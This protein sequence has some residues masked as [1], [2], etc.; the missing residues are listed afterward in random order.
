VL[1]SNRI[2]WRGFS[3]FSAG[4]SYPSKENFSDLLR[5]YTK[6][7]LAPALLVLLLSQ[8]NT[9]ALNLKTSGKAQQ[10]TEKKPDTPQGAETPK[11][12]T[13]PKSG[14]EF[15][16][17]QITE[18]VILTY[19]TRPGLE[20]IRR[21]GIERG[22]MTRI[23]TDGRT[24]EASYERRFIRGASADK[25]K[26]R[27]DQK[28]PTIEY[29]LVYGEGHMWGLINGSAFTPREDATL[30][31]QA[32]LWHGLDALLRYK[33]N[34]S[35]V[36]LGGK[37]KQLGVEYY[38]IDLTDKEKRHTR[39]YI[40]TKTLRV[41]WLEY[42]E[43]ARG[44]GLASAKF[45]RR[46]YDYRLA[47]GTLVPYRTVFFEDGKQTQETRIMTVTFGI[48]MEDSLFQNPDAPRTN[49]ASASQ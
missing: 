41:M 33:E 10:Q 16:A 38:V 23:G 13:A 6:I 27:L 12:A 21:N 5:R 37:E 2:K 42:E 7:A 36:A 9:F 25:D 49:A 14:M 4:C 8:S 30:E 31:F 40:S 44:P 17:D 46:F 20:Q 32:Q 19:G 47:Q 43:G 1:Q 26:V 34:G 48:K 29:S 35:T 18:G 28:L 45:M 3:R 24:E 15:T 11:K 22:R 39:Y